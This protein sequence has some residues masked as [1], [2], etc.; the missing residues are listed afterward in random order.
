MV[1]KPSQ[2]P[3]CY[4]ISPAFL[5][6]PLTILQISMAARFGEVISQE[7][8]E[9]S[10]QTSQEGVSGKLQPAAWVSFYRHP[11]PMTKAAG[12]LL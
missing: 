7:L 3:P 6:S 1:A 5:N 10:S 11:G 4:L 2:I 8:S 9:P 12:M